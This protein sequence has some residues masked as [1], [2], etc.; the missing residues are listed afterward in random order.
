MGW[1]TYYSRLNNY[2][3]RICRLLARYDSMLV[4]EESLVLVLWWFLR[5]SGD[6][7]ASWPWLCP[8][9]SHLQDLHSR[10]SSPGSCQAPPPKLTKAVV[11]ASITRCPQGSGL[12]GNQAAKQ[13]C[14]CKEL[15]LLQWPQSSKAKNGPSVYNFIFCCCISPLLLN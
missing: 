1:N 9:G 4:W 15:K 2:G 3:W 11:K 13:C 8:G 6:P 7:T 14:E 10:I 12:M 5:S